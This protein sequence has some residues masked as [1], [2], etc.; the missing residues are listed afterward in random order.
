MKSE[1]T[2]AKVSKE[3]QVNTKQKNGPLTNK[4]KPKTRIMI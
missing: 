1:K 4:G 3:T 2:E